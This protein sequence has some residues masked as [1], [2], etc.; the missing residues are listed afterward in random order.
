M[1]RSRCPTLTLALSLA[2]L[3][4]P[5]AAQVTVAVDPTSD[6]RPISPLIYGVNFP[7]DA[8]LEQAGLT[9]G[10]WG[11][12]AV[13]R[14]NYEIDVF[15]TAADY[16]F[17]NIPGCWGADQNYCS[18]PPAD[19]KEQSGANA[20]LSRMKTQGKV[21][22]F[23]IPTIGWVAKPPPK[24]SHPFDCGC[25]ASVTANQSSFDPYDT[26]CGD[27][28]APGGNGYVP[29]G[30]PQA[31]SVATSPDWARQWV[32]Y[33]V[34][35]FG[36]ANGQRIY[37]LDNEPALWSSTHRD[38]RTQRLGYDE[39]WQRMRDYAVAI[40][41][42]D[43]TAEISGPAEWGWPNYFCSDLDD[44]SQGCFASSPDRAAH[45]GVELVAWLLDQAKAYEDQNGKRILHYLDLHYYPQGGDPPEI[46]RSL[47]DPDYTD[48]SWINDN[49]RL[50]P[51]MREW[52]DQHYPGTKLAVSEYDFYHHDEPIGA[53]T[54]AEVLGLFAREGVHVATAWGAPGE[55]EIAF[56]AFRL[57]GSFDGQGGRFE[58]VS[59]RATV[60][61]GAGE[62][63]QAYAA[64][65]QARMTVALV[66]EDPEDAEVTVTMG[67]FEPGTT[68]A[69]YGN[70][71]GAQISKLA[72]VA[73]SGGQAV[74][75]L[76]GT[77]IAMLVVDGHNPNELPDGGTGS[78]GS[79]AGGSGA[80]AG[81]AGNGADPGEDEGCG[82]RTAGAGGAAALWA[83][84]VAGLAA[85]AAATRRLRRRPRARR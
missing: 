54:Y 45:G 77:S 80:G 68:A 5:A 66:N 1:R 38:I 37:A 34:S 10:R 73:V 85:A 22:L 32:A 79:G 60:T 21:A 41:D 63:V 46:T 7:S 69:L 75:T 6:A 52:V 42:A 56:A 12:N 4:A 83:T 82:C 26:Q 44:V 61:N 17:E 33:I 62:R 11:G 15:N 59:V 18:S 13:T 31:T 78:G 24:Y 49:I 71:G 72:D 50:L 39:L 48:P 70:G 8:Q 81:G 28:I 53:V 2:A 27:G 55:G 16:Y 58:P 14:Y 35:K 51:R 84:S 30:G 20:F 47:W 74:V 19:P 25:P 3:S 64:V 36:P 57:F 23:T 43:P 29:C 65:G 40:L 67:N 9:V 76:P